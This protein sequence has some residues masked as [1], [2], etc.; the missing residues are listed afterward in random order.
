MGAF[1]SMGRGAAQVYAAVRT[2]LSRTRP[3][4]VFDRRFEAMKLSLVPDDALEPLAIGKGGHR[5]SPRQQ[6]IV[7]LAGPAL[8]EM[9][10]KADL[11]GPVAVFLGLP[12]SGKN[13]VVPSNPE[14]LGALSRQADCAIDQA[15][16]QLFPLG[17]AACLVA[18]QAG[19][20]H[21]AQGRADS[22][23][24]G[25]ADTFFEGDLL[26]RLDREGRI[27]GARSTDGFVPGEGAAFFQIAAGRQVRAR[28]LGPTPTITGVGTAMDAGHRYANQPARGEG[29][30][31]ALATVASLVQSANPIA[32]V[33]GSMNGESFDAKQWGVARLRHGRLFS[34]SARLHHPA[35]S[36]GDTGAAA[37]A[38]LVTM[39]ATALARGDRRGPALVWASS[40]QAE[41]AC[42]LLE[43][44][45]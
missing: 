10:A 41:R 8:R 29:L 13:E 31:H 37:G 19:L 6:R 38:L 4:T 5:L 24:I 27:L 17:R 34:P 33:Y 23:V 28:S 30:A 7:R 21:L 43:V 40:D 16:S 12:E 35:D 2:G 20:R 32:T 11:T 15:A 9:A 45:D 3:S 42:A 44:L 22:V 1:C 25:G 39:A 14:H 18:L 36:T 26:R